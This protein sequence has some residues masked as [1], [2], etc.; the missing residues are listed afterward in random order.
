MSN[1]FAAGS[2]VDEQYRI[3][4]K[5]GEGG[6]GSVYKAEEFLLRR[7]VAI[8]VL[9]STMS[10]SQDSRQRFLREGR[11]LAA[12]NHP[13]ILKCYRFGVWQGVW[14]YI[15]MEYMTGSSLTQRLLNGESFSVA[16]ILNIVSQV[17]QAME[18]AHSKSIVHRDL[19]PSNI[20]LCDGTDD[21][22]RV[23]DFGL[24]M[25]D[26]SDQRLTSTGTVLG[27]IYYM[28]PEQCAGKRVDNRSDIYSLGCVLHQLLTG[29]PPFDADNPIGMMRMHMHEQVGAV[30]TTVS[31][32][33]M[34]AGLQS[35]L[36]RAMDKSLSNRYQSMSEMRADIETVACG[37]G[38]RIQHRCGGAAS[39]ERTVPHSLM[40]V[41]PLLLVVLGAAISGYFSM[42]NSLPKPDGNVPTAKV[43]LSRRLRTDAVLQQ[44]VREEDRIR[45]YRAWLSQH[46]TDVSIGGIDARFS[47]GRAIHDSNPEECRRLLNSG[48][49]I[50][51]QL[52][53]KS[54]APPKALELEIICQHVV[55][56]KSYLRDPKGAIVQLNEMLNKLETLHDAGFMRAINACRCGI[57]GFA[58]QVDDYQEAMTQLNLYFDSL[59]RCTVVP[60]QKL[61]CMAQLA[62]CLEATGKKG[63]AEKQIVEAVKYC[64][65]EVAKGVMERGLLIRT[66]VKLK[67]YEPVLE[68]LDPTIALMEGTSSA[69]DLV[70]IYQLK[71]DCLLGLKRADEAFEYAR[72]L[73]EKVS[74]PLA[75]KIKLWDMMSEANYQCSLHKENELLQ[76]FKDLF[77]S[78]KSM[79][80]ENVRHM[81]QCA[82][83][84]ASAAIAHGQSR[85]A[86]QL[87]EDVYEMRHLWQGSTDKETVDELEKIS[88]QLIKSGKPGVAKSILS[89]K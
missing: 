50:A 26:G 44:G 18:A 36:W 77:G 22:V 68:V 21:Q 34:P 43:I 79:S 9:H 30:E 8:K 10:G 55:S 14:P 51:E 88:L 38:A 86:A 40:V 52:F 87:L 19:S 80:V 69:E 65:S 46:G 67:Q 42:K 84:S 89:D 27:S 49:E 58:L 3:V 11:N 47:L 20:M 32:E 25:N 29:R 70:D 31:G 13:H 24:S 82:R 63:Q 7:F 5:L 73:T 12:L 4:E 39:P 41:I 28:S 37:N 23:I 64:N 33:N 35:I 61:E 54:L 66:A 78:V 72:N 57:I 76:R 85:T 1:L 59:R 15:V 2:I 62:V 81:L 56:L 74:V 71:F 6:M 60:S 16:R 48:L 83:R 17:C 53:E 45:Y 75:S